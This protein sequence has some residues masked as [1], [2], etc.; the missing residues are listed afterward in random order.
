MKDTPTHRA[1]R[2]ANQRLSE[3]RASA[4]ASR[5]RNAL[6]L[7]TLQI[8]ALG[9]GEERPVASNDTEAGRASNRRI[10][11]VIRTADPS[12]RN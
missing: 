5:L 8:Q 10:D 9:Y 12:G 2:A 1:A 11:V 7:P 6:A 4:V 3:E